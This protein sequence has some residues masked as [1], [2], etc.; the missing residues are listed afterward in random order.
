MMNCIFW[1]RNNCT[2]DADVIQQKLLEFFWIQKYFTEIRYF[3]MF[4]P[5]EDK[6]IPGMLFFGI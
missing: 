6:Y 1:D 3:C 2:S 5:I 4:C